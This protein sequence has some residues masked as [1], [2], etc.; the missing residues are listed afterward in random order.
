MIGVLALVIAQAA[1]PAIEA[2]FAGRVND[3]GGTWTAY[4]PDENVAAAVV[5]CEQCAADNIAPG[6]IVT[7]YVQVI[8]NTGSCIHACSGYNV[9]EISV[10]SPYVL[11]TPVSAGPLN[12]S[13]CNEG[14]YTWYVQVR[15]PSTP[16]N[17]PLDGSV[18]GTLFLQS[19]VND[20]VGC[21]LDE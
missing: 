1:V 2:S 7:F 5:N 8:A 20:Q 4:Y 11:I 13:I 17:Y 12:V 10:D 6:S 15:A 14:Q 9:S 3:A 16:G 18:S 19:T 21:L